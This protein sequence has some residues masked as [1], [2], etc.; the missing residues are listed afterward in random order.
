MTAP[1]QL[2]G[3]P[4]TVSGVGKDKTSGNKLHLNGEYNGHTFDIF[5]CHF[6]NG[7]IQV[8]NGQTVTA[9]QTLAKVGSTGHSKGPHLHIETK[10]DGR[11]VDPKRFYKMLGVPTVA[12]RERQKAQQPAAP[13]QPQP[14]PEAAQQPVS[15][16][17]VPSLNRIWE[18]QD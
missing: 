7:S 6:Q 16:D 4:M 5:M 1:M 13:Q 12:E 10:I 2:D 11:A 3:V 8:K 15:G 9:G 17:K 18:E 14:A